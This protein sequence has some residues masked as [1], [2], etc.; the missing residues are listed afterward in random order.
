MGNIPANLLT[1]SEPG[2]SSRIRL[3]VSVGDTTV[4][5]FYTSGEVLSSISGL[6]LCLISDDL[7][8]I[9][10]FFSF[11]TESIQR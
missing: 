3:P 6:F 4:D 10:G 1:Q 9:T 11:G 2:G 7:R 5:E 8:V